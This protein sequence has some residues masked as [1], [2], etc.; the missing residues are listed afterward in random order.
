[1]YHRFD[2]L[3]YTPFS[4]RFYR[5]DDDFLVVK[6]PHPI[7]ASFCIENDVLHFMLYVYM[8]MYGVA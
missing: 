7:Y 5:V 3:A 8:F 4:A 1:M 6:G 2:V